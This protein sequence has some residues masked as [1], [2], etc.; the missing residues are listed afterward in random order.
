MQTCQLEFVLIRCYSYVGQAAARRRQAQLEYEAKLKAEME[1]KENSD[2]SVGLLA[3]LQGLGISERSGES[4]PEE[5]G[6]T[7]CEL[8]DGSFN[9][10]VTYH[11]KKIHK[12]CGKHANGMGYN[13]RGQYVSGWSGNCGDGGIGTSSWYLMCKDCHAKYIRQVR[14]QF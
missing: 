8:C 1:A 13:S 4:E 5:G 14:L 12:G 3:L 11:M 6:K 2:N 9:N 7:D 10:P